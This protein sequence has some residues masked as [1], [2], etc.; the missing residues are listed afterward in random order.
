MKTSIV[1]DNN[2]IKNNQKK[3]ENDFPNDQI[4]KILN[5][6]KLSQNA[7]RTLFLKFKTQRSSPKRKSNLIIKIDT[8]NKKKFRSK[9]HKRR[10]NSKTKIK[11]MIKNDSVSIKSKLNILNYSL[12][13]N[14]NKIH[15]RNKKYKKN[16]RYSPKSF[17]KI[18]SNIFNK[19][20]D[21]SSL[22]KFNNTNNINYRDNHIINIKRKSNITEAKDL[23]KENKKKIKI[24]RSQDIYYRN[25]NFLNN[26]LKEYAINF[27]SSN[28]N[29]NN[30]TK[31]INSYK[32]YKSVNISCNHLNTIQNKE[33]NSY[34]SKKK[35]NKKNLYL[36]NNSFTRKLN[37]QT[38]PVTINISRRFSIKKKMSNNHS[39]KINKNWTSIKDDK[40]SLLL[41]KNN[42]SNIQNKILNNNQ[43]NNIIKIN[44][45]NN[46][47]INTDDK[48]KNNFKLNTEFKALKPY[49]KQK[50]IILIGKNI[51]N[52]NKYKYCNTNISSS[53]FNRSNEIKSN[54]L[55][56][57]DRNIL[58]YDN[59]KKY[60]KDNK[61][62]IIYKINNITNEKRRLNDVLINDKDNKYKFIKKKISISNSK[63]NNSKKNSLQKKTIINNKSIINNKKNII[64][65]LQKQKSLQKLHIKQPLMKKL[66]NE[67]KNINQNFI[68]KN[69]FINKVKNTKKSVE[70]K[71]IKIFPKIR[72]NKKYTLTNN[73]RTIT[74]I[75]NINHSCT[76]N[77][78]NN[79]TKNE[80]NN[81]Y[82]NH[83][84]IN[85]SKGKKSHKKNGA[86]NNDIILKDYKELKN[87]NLNGNNEEQK[88]KSK[89]FLRQS[90]KLTK[91]IKNYYNKYNDYPS[92]NIKFYKFGRVIG[93]GAF[94]K[95]N[96]GLH[97]LTGRIVAIKSFNKTKINNEKDRNKIM[98]EIKL[99]KNLKHFSVV[100]LLDT[101]ENEKYIFII[102][103]NVL[104]GDLLTFIKKRNKLPEKTA[105]YIFKQLLQALKYI[106]NKNIVHRDIKLDNILI[107]LNNNIKLCDFGVGKYIQN[108][109]ELLFEQ[110]GTPAYIAPEVIAGEGYEGF[111]VDLWSSGVVLYSL[112]IGSIPFKAKNLNEL[113]SIIMTGNYKQIKGISKNAKDL[114]N[115]LLEVNPKKRINVEEALNHP[116][117]S[118]SNDSKSS[119]FTKAEIILLSKNNVD[120][121][122]SKNEE[123]IENFTIENLDTNKF[124]EN[125]NIKTKSFIF[126]PFNSSYDSNELISDKKNS[127]EIKLE[128]GVYVQNNIILFELDTN[129]LNRQYEL[130]NNGEIDHGVIINNLNETGNKIISHQINLNEEENNPGNNTTNNDNNNNNNDY[131]KKKEGNL[132]IKLEKNNYKSEKIKDNLIKINKKKKP[133]Y[134]NRNKYNNIQ[135]LLT[136]Y[137]STMTFD[138]NILKNMESYGYKKEYT[139]KC[140]LNNDIN[141]CYATYNLLL[142]SSNFTD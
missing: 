93:K 74:S 139:Q 122:F 12:N 136:T 33:D 133:Y 131:L 46:E 60:S 123:I 95:V 98:N 3:I 82:L 72:K 32:N 18:I 104:G 90:E 30:V 26:N 120:Y 142:S 140:I 29:N 47:T 112:L 103:E 6:N 58:N 16:N 11:I 127:I 71:I 70:Q 48:T 121:R 62:P 109:N 132:C 128:K 64:N 85:S 1:K 8:F 73:S 137:S 86:I 22:N 52:S 55:I 138:E 106:H 56:K 76:N 84:Y 135:S 67:K 130:N 91:Y 102:M 42:I 87:N 41:M 2:F 92:S 83:I 49:R 37:S 31:R 114:L 53:S 117:L 89:I 45:K 7:L 34:F 43:L 100:K 118:D 78:K 69:A 101:F 80:E 28:N 23:S 39:C 13:E 21:E 125:K 116:W 15:F 81:L 38:T 44:F 25:Y 68:K 107:D 75:M 108:N 65:S 63:S 24:I 20:E 124:N 94:G 96:L 54:L 59:C 134:S 88:S 61:R 4:S 36:I 97:I 105:K 35:I 51:I 40:A 27:L 99:M 129:V 79:K 50:K 14:N 19:K 5:F 10:N 77:I 113:Q 111:P 17:E 66:I 141:Y 57:R 115:K 9:N 126:A 119:L 110:C